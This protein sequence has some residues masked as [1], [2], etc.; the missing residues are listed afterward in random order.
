L[1]RLVTTLDD[2]P[3]DDLYQVQGHEIDEEGQGLYPIYLPSPLTQ[4]S[5]ISANIQAMTPTTASQPVEL[6]RNHT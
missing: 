6:I 2:D 4:E 1:P 5:E 3:A